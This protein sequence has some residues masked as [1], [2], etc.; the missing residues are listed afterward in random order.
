MMVLKEGFLPLT[1]TAETWGCDMRIQNDKG[2][3]LIEVIVALGVF[4]IGIFATFM[5][6]GTVVKG[7]ANAHRV[8]DAVNWGS[9]R[10]E[11]LISMPYDSHNNGADDD[12][13][14]AIDEADEFFVDGAGSNNDQGGLDDA[15]PTNTADNS[16]AVNSPGGAYTVY[17]NVAEDFPNT[18]MKTV[19][20]IVRN[21]MMNS[22]SR[23]TTVKITNK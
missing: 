13:D 7:N 8:S 11:L 12:G 15:P 22:V 14:G 6:Q 20:F 2:F 9:D 3:T 17:W 4:S 16:V 10:V 5:L 18:N 21:N 1:L 19:R 23:F